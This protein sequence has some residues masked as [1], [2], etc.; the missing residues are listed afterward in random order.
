MWTCD[1]PWENWP[2]CTNHFIVCYNYV[3]SWYTYTTTMC[4]GELSLYWPLTAVFID[5]CFYWLLIAGIGKPL[6]GLLWEKRAL[7][8]GYGNAT[9]RRCQ[10]WLVVYSLGSVWLLHLCTASPNMCFSPP[11]TVSIPFWLLIAIGQCS[12]YTSS[13]LRLT[14][15][16]LPTNVITKAAP[17]FVLQASYKISIYGFSSTC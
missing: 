9:A 7:V 17:C 15:V 8:R 13:D 5:C 2:M 6:K 10:L 16:G 3:L 4:S 14:W 12:F 1:R 11:S